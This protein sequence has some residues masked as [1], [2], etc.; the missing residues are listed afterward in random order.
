MQVE[1]ENMNHVPVQV[2]AAAGPEYD[3]TDRKVVAVLA[4]RIGNGTPGLTTIR[5][6]VTLPV[7]LNA[8]QVATLAVAG[9]LL[10]EGPR[11]PAG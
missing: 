1:I 4:G 10:C 9:H 11:Y 3:G 2:G 6:A 7:T 5:S 8:D